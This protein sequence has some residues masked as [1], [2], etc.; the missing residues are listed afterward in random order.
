MMYSGFKESARAKSRLRKPVHSSCGATAH[1]GWSSASL[2]R[3]ARACGFEPPVRMRISN[4]KG[5][6]YDT[7]IQ[8]MPHHERRF[9][10]YMSA[11]FGRL[12]PGSRMLCPVK[13]MRSGLKLNRLQTVSLSIPVIL[14]ILGLVF[15]QTLYQKMPVVEGNPYGLAD[16]IELLNFIVIICFCL[17]N[18]I[19]GMV[20]LYMR[21]QDRRIGLGMILFSIFIW[22]GYPRLN[23]LVA[24]Y[25]PH[26]EY[27]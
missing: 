10:W 7:R 2:A 15:R 9:L 12:W 3:P 25:L 26:L 19:W 21:R 13:A 11:P 14:V 18:I 4:S 17:I 24:Q 16:V 8:A 23:S 20:V 1:R 6:S 5:H 22:G 27:E